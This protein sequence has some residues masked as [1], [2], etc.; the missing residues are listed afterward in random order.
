MGDFVRKDEA[1]ESSLRTLKE[2]RKAAKKREKKRKK[3][4][5]ARYRERM[6]ANA[7]QC[8]ECENGLYCYCFDDCCGKHVYCFAWTW[9]ENSMA[10]GV[11]WCHVC[12][13][14]YNIVVWALFT[15]FIYLLTK[16]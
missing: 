10:G 13:W 4:Q 6:N 1:L 3:Q 9:P 7:P 2:L 15:G 5:R 14:Y 8:D 12:P 16:L 11:C